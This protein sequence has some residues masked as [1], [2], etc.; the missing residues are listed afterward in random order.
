MRIFFR[1]VCYDAGKSIEFRAAA[2][3][4]PTQVLLLQ[5][6]VKNKS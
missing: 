1:L 3:A 2:V 5:G 4:V 6:K